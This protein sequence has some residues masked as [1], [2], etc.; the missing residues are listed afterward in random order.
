MVRMLALICVAILLTACNEINEIT[1][2]EQAGP[3]RTEAQWLSCMRPSYCFTCKPGFGGS[4]IGP[5]EMKISSFCPGQEMVSVEITPMLDYYENG[6]RMLRDEV[7][8]FEVLK[9]CR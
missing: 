9:A 1:H 7:R 2:S 5:C 6:E 8:L 4:G 3:K